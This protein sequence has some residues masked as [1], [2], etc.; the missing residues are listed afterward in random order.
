M[1]P[2]E[3]AAAD[4]DGPGDFGGQA[5]ADAGHCL[6][7]RTFQRTAGAVLLGVSKVSPPYLV[8]AALV[9]ASDLPGGQVPEGPARILVEP[10]QGVNN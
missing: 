1:V 10:A 7:H 3:V 2:E 5:L 6:V 9:V 4:V 8:A